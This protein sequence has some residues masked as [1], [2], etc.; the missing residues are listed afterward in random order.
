MD[1]PEN[2]LEATVG[3]EPTMRVLQTPT[4]VSISYR[5]KTGDET[6]STHS[7]STWHN[8]Y[9]LPQCHDA[10]TDRPP[11]PDQHLPKLHHGQKRA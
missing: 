7:F 11:V 6:F 4:L 1:A 10:L 2:E 3:F 9:E 8:I 5:V